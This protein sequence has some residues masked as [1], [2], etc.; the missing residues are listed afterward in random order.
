MNGIPNLADHTDCLK[1]DKHFWQLVLL[2]VISYTQGRIKHNF[3][4]TVHS[5]VKK[6]FISQLVECTILIL[7]L[8]IR[9]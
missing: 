7:Y 3:N 5:V 6:G 9:Y 2:N 1:I 8:V 4:I